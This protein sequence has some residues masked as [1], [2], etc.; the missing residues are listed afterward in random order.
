MAKNEHLGNRMLRSAREQRVPDLG[1]YLIT[2]DTEETER[3]YINGLKDSLPDTLKGR[4]VIKIIDKLRT[5]N[6]ISACEHDVKYNTQYCKPWIM[7]DRDQVPNFNQIIDEAKRRNIGAAWSNPC[8]EIWLEAYFGTMSN[9]QSSV[10]CCQGFSSVFK[11]K[12]NRNYKKSDPDLYKILRD[13]GDESLAINI[14]EQKWHQC[15]QNYE[16]YSDM[17]PC[18]TVHKLIKE[19][20]DAVRD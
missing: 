8:F 2:T 14:A 6:L 5:K 7:F 9:Y 3:N 17:C 4:I 1:Y 19:I 15:N 12:T 11:N 10:A 20:R 18:T 16:L 13:C